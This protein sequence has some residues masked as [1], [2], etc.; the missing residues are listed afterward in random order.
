M[1]ND[2]DLL[3]RSFRIVWHSRYLYLLVVA[4]LVAASIG[5]IYQIAPLYRAIALVDVSPEPGQPVS[6]SRGRREA[7]IDPILIQTEINVL[8]SEQIARLVIQRLNLGANPGFISQSGG[9]P[10]SLEALVQRYYTVVSIQNE[11]RTTLAL[12]SAS[13]SDPILAA[14]IANTHAN[15]Y[16]KQRLTRKLE[17]IDVSEIKLISPAQ[18]PSKPYYPRKTLMMAASLVLAAVIAA[19]LVIALR[20]SALF[21]ADPAAFAQA[22]GLHVL[23]SVPLKQWG[24]RGSARHVF[25]DRVRVVS[26]TVL[27]TVQNESNVIAIVSSL[28][29]EGKSR[30]SF[31]LAECLA[32]ASFET[33]LID[34]DLRKP[35]LL[36]IARMKAELNLN[37][38]SEDA[39]VLRVLKGAPL[40]A[41]TINL[42]PNLDLLPA[43]VSGA[44]KIELLAGEAMRKLLA[45]ARSRYQF[46]LLDTPPLAVVSEGGV[47][48]S[49][50]D[51][52]LFILNGSASSGR[53]LAESLKMLLNLR[54]SVMGIIYTGHSFNDFDIGR[55]R[56]VMDY[57]KINI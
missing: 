57:Y 13:S 3:R 18:P 52:S 6:E 15:V 42:R 30:I 7:A 21:A 23:A 32:L 14:S 24:N 44:S 43:C 31:E 9:Q 54:A 25:R 36:T 33:L 2:K 50:A 5:I 40:S 37:L 17:S 38:T 19:L 45:E 39:G 28:P 12:L 20:S 29:R 35:S 22:N 27:R 26:E 41:E 11:D 34:A 55:D 8:R 1:Q 46:V 53:M 48:A 16:L 51:H 47:L 49:M 4:I 56:K 10:S